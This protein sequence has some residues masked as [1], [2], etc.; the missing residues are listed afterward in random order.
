MDREEAEK[1]AVVLAQ[2]DDGCSVCVASITADFARLYPD[3][4]WFELVAPHADD[5]AESLAK[6]AA[7]L[8]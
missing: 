2:V 5:D 6:L 4:P 3:H 1:I 7:D 8:R